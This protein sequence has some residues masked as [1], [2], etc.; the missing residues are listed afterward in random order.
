MFLSADVSSKIMKDSEECR[1]AALKNRGR[2]VTTTGVEAHDPGHPKRMRNA[3]GPAPPQLDDG[4]F[5]SF[6]VCVSR[7]RCVLYFNLLSTGVLFVWSPI[8]TDLQLTWKRKIREQPAASSSVSGIEGKDVGG[9]PAASDVTFTA[10]L[11]ET[12]APSGVI[13]RVDAELVTM[14]PPSGDQMDVF[15][16]GEPHI[17]SVLYSRSHCHAT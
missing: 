2:R 14:P 1:A 4:V 12:A 15:P 11:G 13:S 8:D 17:A 5:L 9:T 16:R 10:P 6:S 3:A 7:T